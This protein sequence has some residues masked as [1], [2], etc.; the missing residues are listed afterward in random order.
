MSPGYFQC[1]CYL[2]GAVNQVVDALLQAELPALFSAAPVA[3]KH[4]GVVGAARKAVVVAAYERCLELN[5]A[6]P[7]SY[8]AYAQA[9]AGTYNDV[10]AAI[11]VLQR[12]LTAIAPHPRQQLHEETA[13]YIQ[14]LRMAQHQKRLHQEL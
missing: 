11:E 5:L 4:G 13:G 1:Q 2:A 12:M 3:A 8:Q 10:D 14:Q 9:L 6:N 7:M